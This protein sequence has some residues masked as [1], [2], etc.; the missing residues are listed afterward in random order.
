MIMNVELGTLIFQ[1]LAMLIPFCLVIGM[2]ILVVLLVK[3]RNER[4]KTSQ[5]LDQILALLE[6]E[7]K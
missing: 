4:K 1:L 5:K 3:T 6:K 7:Q 2:I